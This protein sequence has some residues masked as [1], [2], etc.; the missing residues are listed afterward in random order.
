MATSTRSKDDF[1][2][3]FTKLQ[4]SGTFEPSTGN[5]LRVYMHEVKS[6]RT[7]TKREAVTDT[8]NGIN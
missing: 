6:K 8:V 1:L 3:C 5:A 2:V 7:N 4:I